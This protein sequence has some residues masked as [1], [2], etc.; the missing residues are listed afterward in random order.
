MLPLPG[1]GSG[2][3]AL[4]F[5]PPPRSIRVTVGGKPGGT[6]GH[7]RHPDACTGWQRPF[8]AA[9]PHEISGQVVGIPPPS[10]VGACARCL[11]HFQRRPW[12]PSARFLPSVGAADVAGGAAA[13]GGGA[14]LLDRLP[15]TGQCPELAWQH[16]PM[17]GPINPRPARGDASA[18]RQW[19]RCWC[20]V[21]LTAAKI[22]T[23]DRWW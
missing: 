17:T 5:S 19:F 6:A 14:D 9:R 4:F 11:W 10:C 23:S 3:S 7:R 20:L 13:G 21:L 18:S 2:A 12:R 1:S 8:L 22:H 16:L 15:P